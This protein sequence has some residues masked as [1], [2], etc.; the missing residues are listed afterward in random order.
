M[1]NDIG[2]K[3]WH[4]YHTFVMA[5]HSLILANIY[6]PLFL[7]HYCLRHNWARELMQKQQAG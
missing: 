5:G 4:L 7:K 3:V 1:N 2:K 6:R